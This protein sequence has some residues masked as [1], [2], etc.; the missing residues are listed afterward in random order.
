[1]EPTTCSSLTGTAGRSE[2]AG[3]ILLGVAL[4]P[5]PEIVLYLPKYQL[6]NTLNHL[7]CMYFEFENAWLPILML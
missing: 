4:R 7:I 1:M 3:I 2:T 5:L 6:F